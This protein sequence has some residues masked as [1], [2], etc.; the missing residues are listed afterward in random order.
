MSAAYKPT[1]A[2]HEVIRGPYHRTTA[3]V[4]VQEI[5][6]PRSLTDRET[7]CTPEDRRLRVSNIEFVKHDRHTPSSALAV[8]AEPVITDLT[9]D[10][11]H[12]SASAKKSVN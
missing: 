1:R 2:P 6:I 11:G 10:G 9:A 4:T 7:A 3:L 5:T 8:P 12:Q